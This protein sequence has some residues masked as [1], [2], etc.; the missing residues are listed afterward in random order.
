ML[1]EVG[2]QRRV[3]VLENKCAR[4]KVS[5]TIPKERG[6]KLRRAM[7]PGEHMLWWGLR[8]S[9]LGIKVRRPHPSGPYVVNFCSLEA[10]LTI[11]IDGAQHDQEENRPADQCRTQYLEQQGYRVLRLWNNELL[12]DT[13]SALTDIVDFLKGLLPGAARRPLPHP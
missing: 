2:A 3:R 5:A 13:N 7:T 8:N 11:E 4:A 10:M 9:A 6:R 1:G 12:S